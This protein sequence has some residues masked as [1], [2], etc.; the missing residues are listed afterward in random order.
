VCVD[1]V[2]VVLNKPM[3]FKVEHNA[4]KKLCKGDT[5]VMEATKGMK[6][7]WW[8]TG[9]RNARIVKMVPDSS[10]KVV[11]EAVDSNG[12]D[13]RKVLEITVDTCKTNS[14]YESQILKDDI[15]VFPN[16][17]DALLNIDNLV[18][19]LSGSEITITDMQGRVLQHVT[20]GNEAVLH[21][22]LTYVSSGHYNL[23][24]SKQHERWV[25]RIVVE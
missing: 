17:A 14:A 23:I 24:I 15:L 1:S 8:S 2:D 6:S 13:Y 16:P 12:C 5:L 21:L 10:M 3:E 9:Q 19:K 18:G 11:I 22:D 7:Y 25:K 4:G 20:A